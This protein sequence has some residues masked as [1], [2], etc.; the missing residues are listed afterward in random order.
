MEPALKQRLIGAAVL[1]A[2]AVIFLPMLVQGPAPGKR[3]LRRAAAMPDAP[4]GELRNPRPA[5]G[6]ARRRAGRRRGRHAI[7]RAAPRRRSRCRPSDTA[8]RRRSA[9]E[10]HRRRRWAMTRRDHRADAAAAPRRRRDVPGADRRRRLRGEF[11]RVL[12]QR[13]RPTRSSPRCARRSCPAIAKRRPST[14]SRS[15]ACASVPTPPRRGRGRA[16][17][18]RA[19]ARRCRR[20]G[21]RA[22]CRR[23]RAPTPPSRVADRAAKPARH[24]SAAKPAPQPRQAAAA[25]RRARAAAGTGFAV[26]LAAFSKA[27]DATALRDR[28]RAAG[29]SAFTEAVGTDKGTLTR[30]RVGP[31]AESRR[32]RSAEGAGQGQGRHRRHRPSASL[33]GGCAQ[34]RRHDRDSTGCCWR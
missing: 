9:V 27:A 34:W 32:G 21:G 28:L 33:I 25:A 20:A 7:A 10:Q 29:F 16:P 4:A 26:Q 30:V 13:G 8:D 14:A 31:V 18:R 12:E 22:G 11:R 5:A 2:L 6:D 24:A 3:R 19:C 15:S 23:R 17:A 1:V